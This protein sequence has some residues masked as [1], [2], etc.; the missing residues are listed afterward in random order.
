MPDFVFQ[1]LCNLIASFIFLFSILLFFRPAIKISD[2]IAS[3]IDEDGKLCFRI[4]FYNQSWF[5][6]YD[7]VVNL[8][9]LEEVSAQPGG[10]DIYVRSLQ[11]TTSNFPYLNKYVFKPVNYANHCI[12][13]KTLE[14]LSVILSDRHKSLQI[15]ITLK[16]GLTGLSKNFVK[17]FSNEKSI[18]NGRYEFGN[19]IKIY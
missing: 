16:H 2:K 15:R 12:Q 10:K 3:H 5:S 19:C 13:V 8:R 6:G 18:I 17:N 7:V 11:L 4:K 1:V 14:D 9:E